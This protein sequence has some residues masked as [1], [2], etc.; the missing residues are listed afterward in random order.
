[1]MKCPYTQPFP[2]IYDECPYTQLFPMIYDEMPLHTTIS[3]DL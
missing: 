3:Y 2:M 1:M